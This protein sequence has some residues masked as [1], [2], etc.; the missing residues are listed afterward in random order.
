MKRLVVV[1]MIA[2]FALAISPTFVMGQLIDYCEGDF[3]C[4]GDCDGTDAFTF[5]T[6]FGRSTFSNPCPSC[7]EELQLC[8]Y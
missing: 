4:D 7:T 8:S 5:K 3:D 1:L 2:V 6:D